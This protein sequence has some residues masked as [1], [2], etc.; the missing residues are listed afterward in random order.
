MSEMEKLMFLVFE[1]QY[2]RLSK[3][4]SAN[5]ITPQAIRRMMRQ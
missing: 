5:D 2:L 3:R 4:L 1:A